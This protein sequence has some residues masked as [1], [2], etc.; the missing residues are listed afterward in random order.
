LDIVYNVLS[1]LSY[2]RIKRDLI[3]PLLL[4]IISHWLPVFLEILNSQAENLIPSQPSTYRL[5]IS[6]LQVLAILVASSSFSKYLEPN[7]PLI[8]G[9]IWNNIILAL[10]I[11]EREVVN[12]PE[13]DG[14]SSSSFE[15]DGTAI[16]FEV[17]FHFL[18]FCSSLSPLST[19]SS[20]HL[21]L[22]TFLSFLL[23]LLFLIYSS[24]FT[25]LMRQLNS[26]R[27]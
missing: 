18:F 19:L 27:S 11:Y 9:P 1:W 23:R 12:N 14:E 5:K 7:V 26:E 6:V 24:S 17:V 4:N 15:D 3:Q 20:P 13:A 8:L 2:A 25:P 21:L 22:L 16:G 10:G